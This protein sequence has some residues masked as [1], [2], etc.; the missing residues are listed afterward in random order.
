[1]IGEYDADGVH[2]FTEVDAF[3][4]LNQ[5][6]IDRHRRGKAL[7][8]AISAGG[9]CEPQGMT[10]DRAEAFDAFLKGWEAKDDDAA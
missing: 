7:A 2:R 1:M 3:A 4:S 6:A 8:L 5:N 10:L 9:G